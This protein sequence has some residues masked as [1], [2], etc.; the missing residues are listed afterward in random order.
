MSRSVVGV[1]QS[2]SALP[3]PYGFSRSPSC[4]LLERLLMLLFGEQN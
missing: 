4:G 2:N 1:A 3:K